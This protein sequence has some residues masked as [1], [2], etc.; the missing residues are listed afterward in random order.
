MVLS[1][2]NLIYVSFKNANK[3]QIYLTLLPLSK[4]AEAW[5]G[6][7]GL[8]TSGMMGGNQKARHYFA[9]FRYDRKKFPKKWDYSKILKGSDW[10]VCIFM[11]YI[12]HHD[13]KLIKL[14][15]S[16]NVLKLSNKPTE[17]S[18]GNIARITA[19]AISPGVPAPTKTKR[20]ARLA[21]CS[22]GSVM[23]KPHWRQQQTQQTV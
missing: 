2:I 4:L 9:I 8:G 6:A 1:S 11:E 14:Y 12:H 15:S 5:G 17:F 3:H 19:S 16:P 10:K 13:I 21:P 7:N 18:P 22:T 20:V 23:M